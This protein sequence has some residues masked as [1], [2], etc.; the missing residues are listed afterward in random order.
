MYKYI[1]MSNLNKIKTSI[2]YYHS[3]VYIGKDF[4]IPLKRVMIKYWA[5]AQSSLNISSTSSTPV[6]IILHIQVFRFEHLAFI[7][8]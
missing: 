1:S 3:Y 2:K 4:T 7:S 8:I 6:S 5:V